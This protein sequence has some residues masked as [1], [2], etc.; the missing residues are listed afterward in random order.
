MLVASY[1]IEW[2]NSPQFYL[3]LNMG[4]FG[5]PIF[6][7]SFAPAFCQFLSGSD[8]GIVESFQGSS[9][10]VGIIRGPYLNGY[11]LIFHIWQWMFLD[12]W[13]EC[14]W[15]RSTFDVQCWTQRTRRAQRM[16]TDCAQPNML[17]LRRKYCQFSFCL[18]KYRRLVSTFTLLHE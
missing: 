16:S 8:N 13:W 15:R 12:P 17:W 7:R 5:R 14:R 11:Q 18:H 9:P 1:W 4:W 6:I 10:L 2:S 3:E